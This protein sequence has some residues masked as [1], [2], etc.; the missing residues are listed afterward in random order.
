MVSSHLKRTIRCRY[1]NNG[2][3]VWSVVW[4]ERWEA[5]MI[6]Y[7]SAN[8]L[9]SLQIRQVSQEKPCADSSR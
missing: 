7:G 6:M 1:H 4:C 5:H 3:P 8:D 2:T 9:S